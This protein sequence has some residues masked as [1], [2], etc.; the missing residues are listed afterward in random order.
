LALATACGAR[1]TEETGEAEMSPTSKT[2]YAI[3]WQSARGFMQQEIEVDAESA[4]QGFRDALEGAELQWSEEELT[5]ALQ[6]LQQDFMQRQRQRMEAQASDN[7]SE[8]EAFLAENGAREGVMT[9]E[10]GLQY[11]VLTSAD[12][13]RPTAGDTVTVH[14]RGTLLDGTEFDSSYARDAPATFGLDRVIAGWTEGLQLMTV[15]SKYKLYVP[16]E[17]AYGSRGAPPK[18]GPGATLVFEVE[19]LAI[20]E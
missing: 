7:A 4:I 13:P 2:S 17:L 12:G 5:A 3:G 10:S 20:E 15:G 6:Q 19:L 16:S 1:A 8:G 18:I 11:E 14:Y 9:T